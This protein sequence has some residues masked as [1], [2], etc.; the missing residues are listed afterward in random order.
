MSF[1][2]SLLIPGLLAATNAKKVKFGVMTDIHLN[3]GYKADISGDSYCE[4]FGKA[5]EV[6]NFGRAHCD[7]PTLLVERLMEKMKAEN[8]DLDVILVPGDMVTH[9]LA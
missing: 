2:R 4:G 3:L 9:G 1:V 8:P 7:S 5:T 6:A